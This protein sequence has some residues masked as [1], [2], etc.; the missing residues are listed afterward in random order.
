VDAQYHIGDGELSTH[1][2]TFAGSHELH[3]PR[4]A[5]LA[6]HD[7]KY[8]RERAVTAEV[9]QAA[10]YWTA[11]K[12]SEHPEGFFSGA[13]RRRAPSLIA[14]HMSPDAVSVGYQ[15]HDLRPGR[16]RSGDLIKWTSP[17][18][19]RLFLGTHP[20]TVDEVR[21]GTGRLWLPEGLTRMHALTGLGE[22]AASYAGCWA[23]RQDGE[24]LPCFDHVNLDGRLVLDVPDA[25][26][27]TNENV[28]RALAERVAF[29]ESRG[30]RVLVVSVPEV[31]D[32]PTAGLD[33]YLA[34]GGDLGVLVRDAR[35]YVS[36]DTGRERLKRDEELRLKQAA[37]RVEV[38]RL[39]TNT[40]GECGA[41]KFAR[42][43]VEVC[44]PAHGKVHARGVVVHPSLRQASSGIRV[45][46]NA[47]RNALTYLEGIGFLELMD[48]PRA[49]NAAASYLLIDPSLGG[50]AL[51][52]HMETMGGGRKESQ[53][54]G[55]E[56]ET[57][58]H[59]RESSSRVHSMHIGVKS[60]KDSEKL[61]A[62]RNSKLVHTWERR[63]GRRV[64]V[65]SDF[66][67]RYGA[68][69]EL[70][71]RYVLERG[72]V[73]VSE[74][75]EK[76]GSKTAR[77]GRFYKT[78]VAPMV[79]DGVLV[80]DSGGVGAAPDW[81]AALERVQERTDELRD[82]RLQDQK[83]AKQREAFRK[84]K[85]LPTDPT[86]ELAGPERVTEIVAKAAERD[87]AARVE[88]QRQ[89]VGTT[90]ETFLEDALQD[91]SG[92]G[93]RELRA[94]WVAKGGKPEH[95]R[96]AVE[97]PYRFEREGGDGP[98]YVVK[99]GIAPGP[100]RKPA[101]V[102]VLRDADNPATVAGL[103]PAS[104]EDWRSHPLD[105]ECDECLSPLLKGYVLTG[106]GT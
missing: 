37:K 104:G 41:V 68:K 102:A 46:M 25:D 54:H 85:D 101:T 21:S 11:R 3:R 106:S 89:K 84:A 6:D 71:L 18:G 73:G 62:L 86:P 23:W 67:K 7:A 42:Y 87:H 92:F 81:M 65:H 96:R 8:L 50:R 98:L 94:L 17:K 31:N 1:T 19:A 16:D 80:G 70:M 4:D 51:G 26:Y 12:P 15:K 77:R 82:N 103:E 93:W 72:K 13:Q 44:I 32:D 40:Q 57:S 83:Y 100:E 34:A 53:E 48:K 63:N 97:D 52:E 59:Q 35:P 56:D 75:L 14:P 88:E 61:P 95:L 20:W 79:D 33:D 74:L 55:E 29:L 60:E 78:W 27:R 90:P 2:S 9:A 28:Q 24:P 5:T 66:F 43:I 99:A 76:F 39:P 45:S 22:A 58:L 38:E 36:T 64:V 10:G 30:A 91:A 47:V 105:C 69:G 49:R